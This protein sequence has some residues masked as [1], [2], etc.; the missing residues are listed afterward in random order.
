MNSQIKLYSYQ[1][2]SH[3]FVVM[4]YEKEEA[5]KKILHLLQNTTGLEHLTAADNDGIEVGDFAL[6]SYL[7]IIN[8]NV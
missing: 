2:G 1:F 7:E 5:E 6:S 4:A 8:D 3:F